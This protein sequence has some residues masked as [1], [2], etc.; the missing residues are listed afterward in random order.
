MA[1]S[2]GAEM[3]ASFMELDTSF[4]AS[5]YFQPPGQAVRRIKGGDEGALE[6]IVQKPT[7]FVREEAT[8]VVS[9]VA[10]LDTGGYSHFFAEVGDGVF[11]DE[12]IRERTLDFLCIWMPR[13]RTIS[14]YGHDE[15]DFSLQNERNPD[16]FRMSGVSLRG[17]RLKLLSFS[18]E[19]DV[20][21]N[22]GHQHFVAGRM[23][24]VAWVNFFGREMIEA[25]GRE[26]LL[27]ASWFQVRE[28]SDGL[29]ALLYE[30]PFDPGNK[31]KRRQQALVREQLALDQIA[32]RAALGS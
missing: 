3:V 26:R 20:E 11:R 1:T 32:H 5:G 18:R 16:V 15:Q 17:Y 13:I 9:S 14:G 22:P 28:V 12:R 6:E 29:C 24:T 21:R 30:D 7:V 31:A 10:L 25:I 2:L 8:S 23:F 27:S 19:I 4:V